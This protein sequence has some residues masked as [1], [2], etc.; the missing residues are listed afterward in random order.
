MIMYGAAIVLST[1]DSTSIN[2]RYS[3]TIVKVDTGTV[4]YDPLVKR[5]PAIV[6]QY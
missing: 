4:G 3:D 2:L 1:I 5:S 6:I